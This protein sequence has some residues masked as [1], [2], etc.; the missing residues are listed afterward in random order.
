[1]HKISRIGQVTIRLQWQTDVSMMLMT[2]GPFVRRVDGASPLVI[3]MPVNDAMLG[4]ELKVEV[5][6]F[7]LSVGVECPFEL[8]VDWE[9]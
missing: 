3:S 6:S 1:V 8:T 7:E 2:H 9:D 5:T 4:R